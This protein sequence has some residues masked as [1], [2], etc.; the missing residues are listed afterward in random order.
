MANLKEETNKMDIALKYTNGDMNLAKKMVAGIY[1]DLYTIKGRVELTS[2]LFG[3]FFINI[4]QKGDEFAECHFFATA[5]RQAGQTKGF[6]PIIQIVTS[7]TQMIQKKKEDSNT[8]SALMSAF[9]D[10]LSGKI[11]R[12]IISA[13]YKKDLNNLTKLFTFII[14]SHMQFKKVSIQL[15]IEETSSFEW[16]YK[17]LKETRFSSVS[18][19]S[20]GDAQ[21]SD[22]PMDFM[23]SSEIKD[24]EKNFLKIVDVEVVVSPVKG[25]LMRDLMPGVKIKIILP[26]ANQEQKEFAQ[27]HGAFNEEGQI[28]AI[29]ASFDRYINLPGNKGY[30]I[31]ASLPDKILC[32]AFEESFVKLATVS[33][34]KKL[35]R[36]ENI[37]NATVLQADKFSSPVSIILA[38]AALLAIVILIMIFI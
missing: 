24:F 18:F 31:Y 8:T 12:E 17:I 4:K 30:I 37:Q 6:M 23:D 20:T 16:E 29:P 25:I 1:K 38:I 32:R 14:S 33:L 7:L 9:S 2:I 15:G 34:Q 27:A 26:I 11:G 36:A 21:K 3:F 10:S 35:P 28:Q 5:D 19:G 13:A 22:V